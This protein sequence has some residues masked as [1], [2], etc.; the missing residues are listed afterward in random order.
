MYE[1]L[2]LFALLGS[3]TTAGVMFA[4]AL[5]VVPALAAMPP[6]R[7][8]EA[9][10]LL[11]RNWDPTMPV[12]VLSTALAD[13]VLALLAPGVAARS[14]HAAAVVLV[15]GVA[16][17]SHL[18]NVPLNRA[19]K[20]LGPASAI[21]RDWADPRPAW[22]G[23]HLVRTALAGLAFLVNAAAAVLA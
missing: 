13:L 17:V 21:P 2:R 6:A 7:Y 5:S 16:G 14:L 15:L 9:H 10:R 3:G 23:Y 4:V 20:A 11:G 18:L 8:V 19:V 1:F 22:R 12:I